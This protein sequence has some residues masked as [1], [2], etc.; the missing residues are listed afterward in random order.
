[1]QLELMVEVGVVLA[2]L[3]REGRDVDGHMEDTEECQGEHG[4]DRLDNSIPSHQL[5]LCGPR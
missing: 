2:R 5:E 4:G 1:M 3:E